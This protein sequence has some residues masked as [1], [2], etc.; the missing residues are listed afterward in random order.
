MN[1]RALSLEKLFNQPESHGSVIDS[2][3]NLRNNQKERP[4]STK[5][6]FRESETNVAEDLVIQ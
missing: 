5:S 6:D 1:F 3:I 2:F 4:L